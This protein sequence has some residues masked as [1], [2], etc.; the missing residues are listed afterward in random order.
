MIRWRGLTGRGVL[1]GT[2][3]ILAQAAASATAMVLFIVIGRVDGLEAMG[4]YSILY[5][6][7][8]LIAQVVREATLTPL[9]SRKLS[10]DEY[11]RHAERQSMAGLG[12]GAVV[13]L[14]GL[15]LGDAAIIMLGLALHGMLIL[16]YAKLISVTFGTG[17]SA[18]VQE[19]AVL[20]AVCAAGVG[21]LLL[22]W[23]AAAVFGTWLGTAAVVGYAIAIGQRYALRPR[24]RAERGEA[25]VSASFS[26]QSL[27]NASSVH[28]LSIATGAVAGLVTVGV[29]RG[30]ST[31]MG[32]ANLSIT[33]VQ[34]IVLRRLAGYAARS[35]RSRWRDLLGDAVLTSAVFAAIAAV[36]AV[37][38]HFLGDLI[39]GPEV[40]QAVQPILLLVAADGV[41]V[42]I[43]TVARLFH[44]ATWEHKRS[45]AI[46][47]VFV[48]ARWPAVLSAAAMYGAMGAALGALVSSLIGAVLWWYSAYRVSR[49]L[50]EEPAISSTRIS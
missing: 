4:K 50:P 6:V 29:L 36:L 39:L 28:M 46:S 12:L 23:P 38:A 30:A 2:S 17:K 49:D 44:R 21:T 14:V 43:T 22:H 19:S 35:H 9:L 48:S 13:V 1:R 11:K 18:L 10:M 33:A 34:S 7:Y 15:V 25:M 32:P 26:L 47:L 41:L 5:A 37:G 24:W 16:Q 27:I 8:L 42:A 45:M 40:W 20:A 31:V 3:A